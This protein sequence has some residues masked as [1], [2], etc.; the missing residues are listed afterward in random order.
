MAKTKRATKI[1]QGIA[2]IFIERHG[3]IFHEWSLEETAKR[4]REWLDKE[5]HIKKR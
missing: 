4:V 1:E 2:K 3:N 5:G